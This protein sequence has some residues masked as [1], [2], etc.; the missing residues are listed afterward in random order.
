MDNSH[1]M[2]STEWIVGK[3][4]NEILDISDISIQVKLVDKSFW[5]NVKI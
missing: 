2:G 1:Q 3:W 4:K 5:F